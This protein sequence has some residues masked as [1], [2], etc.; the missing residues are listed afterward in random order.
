M[1]GNKTSGTK[2][3]TPR[4]VV[5]FFWKFWKLLVYLLLEVA[6]N[7]NRR[8][9]LKGICQVGLGWRSGRGFSRFWNM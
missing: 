1:N 9:W 5:L 3:L 8:F 6:R 7:L 4:V 2:L